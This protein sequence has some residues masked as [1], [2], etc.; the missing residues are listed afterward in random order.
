M[1]KFRL[2]WNNYARYIRFGYDSKINIKKNIYNR[3][4][5]FFSFLNLI[6]II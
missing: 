5:M 6:N 4:C 2:P 1:L 3:I